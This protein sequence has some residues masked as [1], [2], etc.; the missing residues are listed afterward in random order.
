L[1]TTHRVLRT[2]NGSTYMDILIESLVR[3]RDQWRD[4]LLLAESEENYRLCAFI[5]DKI[6]SIDKKLL[7]IRFPINNLK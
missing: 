6:V 3:E 5:R 4:K 2:I 7:K 1:R